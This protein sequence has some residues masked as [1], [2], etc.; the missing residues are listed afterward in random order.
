ML[1]LVALVYSVAQECVER[2]QLTSLTFM[3]GERSVRKRTE[4]TPTLQCERNCPPGVRVRKVVCVSMVDDNGH[5][6]WKCPQ[7]DIEPAAYTLGKFRVACEGC[8]EKS[9]PRVLKGSCVLRF[10]L[11]ERTDRSHT[12]GT[13][14]RVRSSTTYDT[15]AY[16]RE[17]ASS[18]SSSGTV[19]LLLAAA[20]LVLFFINRNKALRR[21]DHSHAYQAWDAHSQAPPVPPQPSAPAWEEHGKVS[22]GYQGQQQYQHQEQYPH[23]Q[24][25]QQTPYQQQQYS[26]QQYPQQQQQQQQSTGLGNWGWLLG[27]V[28][29]YWLVSSMF[30]VSSQP[31]YQQQYPQQ[32]QQQPHEQ[33]EAPHHEQEDWG[34]QEYDYGDAGGGASFEGFDGS[35]SY[36]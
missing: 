32:Y 35:T 10:G 16:S 14:S 5:L 4:V 19:F 9:D 28:A 34:Q 18:S 13:P 21:V 33:Y 22:Q 23:Q 36:E 24:Y 29:S 27:G 3:E 25:Q 31:Q 30:G 1:L 11:R 20:G 6:R 2:S 7:R 26:Q 8:T 15:S 17:L 12:A